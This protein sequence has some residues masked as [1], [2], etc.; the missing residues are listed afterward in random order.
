MTVH[1]RNAW[2]DADNGC[3]DRLAAPDGVAIHWVG[4][5]LSEQLRLGNKAD[6]AAFLRQCRANNVGDDYCDIEYNWAVA[7]NGDEFACRGLEFDGG[8]NGTTDANDRFVSILVIYPLGGAPTKEQDAGVRR[9]RRRI[10]E[11][12]P[13]AT[14]I[15]PHQSFVP[16]QCPGIPAL[17]RINS[18]V[19]DV[20]FEDL[21]TLR[22]RTRRAKGKL[23]DA[24]DLF[25]RLSRRLARKQEQRHRHE[26]G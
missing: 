6:V 1:H 16:T 21:S 10:M 4:S 14:R 18:G 26:E 19:Y 8:A 7:G 22:R 3:S 2:T 12:Y 20:D 23:L 5:G 15:R 24:R 11:K 17:R 25:R 9:A 13:T